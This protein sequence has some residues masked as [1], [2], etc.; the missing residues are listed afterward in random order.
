LE[1]ENLL[2]ISRSAIATASDS[3]LTLHQVATHWYLVVG[4]QHEEA[5]WQAPTA[6]PITIIITLGIHRRLFVDC[7]IQSILASGSFRAVR[8]VSQSN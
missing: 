6:T 5:C 4:L 3:V 7:A 1:C 8:I 2:V